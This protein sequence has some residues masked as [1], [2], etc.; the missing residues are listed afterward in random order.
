[1]KKV[2]R[3]AVAMSGG[4]D[5]SVAAALLV[6]RGIDTFGL[7]MRLWSADPNGFNRCCS[8]DDVD[9]A[10][11]VSTQLGIPFTTVDVQ[12][13][14]KKYVVDTL[15]D[16]YAH[17]L[18]PNPCIACNKYVRWGF[19]LRHAIDL[20]ATHLATGHY[21]RV[22]VSNNRN[23]L[24][25]GRDKVKDQSY[26]L[27][28][29]GE[30]ELAQTLFPL[31][32]YTKEEVRKLAHRMSLSVAEKLESQDLCFITHGSYRD[33]LLQ[34]GIKLPPPGPIIDQ[35]G[36]VLGQHSGLANYTIGQRR[37]IGISMSYPLY[38]LEKNIS[39]NTLIVGPKET[40]GRSQFRAG[41]VNWISTEHPTTST[42]VRVQV[43]YKAKAVKA[44]VDPLQ[45]G[46]V[47]VAL[48]E[49]LPDITPGQAATFYDD[50][51]CLGGGIILP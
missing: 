18:T 14:F 7:M 40:L 32:D 8:P 19:L 41:P 29:I 30:Q 22:K 39:T 17:G 26:V 48:K 24:M 6:E 38:V 34:Q 31:G 43:R 50:A 20:G 9:T 46:I 36:N 44:T 11:Q 23:Y 12:D 37:G 27:S 5:S 51:I 2:E 25:R 4:V 28:F 49:K 47:N 33:F 45:N 13:L 42:T 35:E 21:A 3:V 10:R 1:M 15:I 16:G